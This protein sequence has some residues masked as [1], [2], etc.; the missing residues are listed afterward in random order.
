MLE[1]EGVEETKTA[2]P[3]KSMKQGSYEVTKI[4]TSSTRPAQAWT[5]SSAYIAWLSIEYFMRVLSVCRSRS[6]IP[7]SSL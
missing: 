7:V 4:E 6:M 5:R 1:S 2:R 3:S